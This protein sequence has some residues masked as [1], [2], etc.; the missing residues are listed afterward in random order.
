MWE[1]KIIELRCE[2]ISL[3]HFMYNVCKYLSEILHL[4]IFKILLFLPNLPNPEMGEG[5]TLYFHYMG[6]VLVCV[7]MKGAVFNQLSVE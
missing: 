3:S 5:V 7:A 1:I 6:Y 4:L 2:V